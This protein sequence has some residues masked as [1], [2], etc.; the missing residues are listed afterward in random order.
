V[1]APH[2]ETPRGS[3]ANI[4]M[5][6][7]AKLLLISIMLMSILI[8][9]RAAAEKDPRRGLKKALVAMALFNLFYALAVTYLYPRLL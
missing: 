9:A 2:T 5:S 3:A 1:L 8:P 4:A 7:P 6:T